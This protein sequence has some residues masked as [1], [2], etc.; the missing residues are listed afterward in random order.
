MSGHIV[1]N[2]MREAGRVLAEARKLMKEKFGLD[3]VTIQIEDEA[4]AAAEPK[5]H[6]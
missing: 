5:L 2:D 6:V 3:H 4:L 1:V